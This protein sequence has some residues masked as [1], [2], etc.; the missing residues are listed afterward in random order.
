ME[1]KLEEL[2]RIS[3]CPEGATFSQLGLRKSVASSADISTMRSSPIV[4]RWPDRV[5]TAPIPGGA[6]RRTKT[7]SG[8]FNFSAI[9]S[10]VLEDA[11]VRH[12]PLEPVEELRG[13]IDLVVMLSI[14]EDGHLVEVFGEPRCGLRDIDK[15]VLDDRGL[16]IQPHGLVG[17]WLVPGDTM[18][19]VGDQF[20]DQLGARGL[21][22][23]QHLGGVEQLLL[24]AH[25]AFER[26]VFEPLAQQAQRGR[27]LAP[28]TPGRT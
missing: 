2:R 1:G 22:L 6:L 13:G 23:D 20:L 17:G 11:L 27:V 16:G 25:R 28:H 5:W 19:A 10:I 4:V 9:F 12:W 18:T 8:G 24:L 15:A 14:G 21:V 26:R 3:N 7:G